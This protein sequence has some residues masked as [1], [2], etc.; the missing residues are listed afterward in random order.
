MIE[1]SEMTA[2]KSDLKS[3]VIVIFGEIKI[4]GQYLTF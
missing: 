3:K 4:T 2:I 1:L